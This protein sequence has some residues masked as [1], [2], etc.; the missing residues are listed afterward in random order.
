MCSNI[1]ENNIIN[2]NV[3]IANMCNNILCV[4]YY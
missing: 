1:N 3:I 2:I 4:I